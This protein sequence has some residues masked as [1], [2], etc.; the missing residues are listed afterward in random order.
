MGFY[1]SQKDEK[2]KKSVSKNRHK[3]LDSPKKPAT[4]AFKTVSNRAIQKLVRTK[5]AAKITKRVS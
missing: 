5:T 3:F 1:R 2:K 4:D